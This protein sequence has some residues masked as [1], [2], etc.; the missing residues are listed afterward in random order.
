MK[1]RLLPTARLSF[2][3]ASALAALFAVPS[4]RAAT[5]TW[6]SDGTTTSGPVDGTGD[7]LATGLWWDG[8]ANVDWNNATFRQPPGAGPRTWSRPIR[9]RGRPA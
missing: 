3:L 6:D 8:A 9:R 1:S 4:A 5:V 7:W 2:A